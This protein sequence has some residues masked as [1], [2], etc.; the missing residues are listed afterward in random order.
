MSREQMKVRLAAATPGPWAASPYIV[1]GEQDD[2]ERVRVTSQHDSPDYNTAEM[3]LPKDADLIAYAPT[4][5]AKL[6]AALD[7]VE[8]L[9]RP[10]Q[11]DFI[12]ALPCIREECECE[13]ECPTE[14]LPVCR[15]CWGQLEQIDPYFGEQH[16]VSEVMWPCPTFTAIRDALGEDQ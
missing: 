13:N 4:D 9:H 12:T 11:E 16:H 14:P 6:H 7:A 8:A 10:I 2:T 1:Y 15:H 5:L 3:V